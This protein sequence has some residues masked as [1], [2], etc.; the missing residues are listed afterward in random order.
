VPIDKSFVR[1]KWRLD[2]VPVPW[3]RGG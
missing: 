1:L 2:E 3:V